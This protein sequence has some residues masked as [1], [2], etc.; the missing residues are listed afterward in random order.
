[1]SSRRHQLL[2]MAAFDCGSP[3]KLRQH[4]WTCQF[5][6]E[7]SRAQRWHGAQGPSLTFNAMI[8]STRPFLQVNWAR[9]PVE[10]PTIDGVTLPLNAAISWIKGEDRDILRVSAVRTTILLFERSAPIPVWVYIYRSSNLAEA[11][12]IYLRI[13]NSSDEYLWR[14]IFQR[15]KHSYH[16]ECLHEG[17]TCTQKTL[18]KWRYLTATNICTT[19][20]HLRRG[21][22]AIEWQ[23]GWKAFPRL[24]RTYSGD[25]VRSVKCIYGYRLTQFRRPTMTTTTNIVTMIIS[26]QKQYGQWKRQ[27]TNQAPTIL[28]HSATNKRLAVSALMATLDENQMAKCNAYRLLSTAAQPASLWHRGFSSD[29]GYQA[30]NIITLA[31]TRGVMQHANDSRTTQNTVQCMDYPAPVDRSD[32]LVVPMDAYDWVLRLPWFP[33]QNPDIDWAR[34]TLCDHRVPVE[35]RNDTDDYGSGIE[36]LGSRE[37]PASWARSG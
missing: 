3:E 13:H 20:V 6:A 1:M 7:T 19:E 11:F 23:L 18:Y 26:E 25:T 27:W 29:L 4:P 22:A 12:D 8:M 15:I 10:A 16:H 33:K 28:R 34:L 31:L 36:G 9:S 32:V 17:C 35:R 5:T 37:W 30:A 24:K 2:P 14:R 21:H